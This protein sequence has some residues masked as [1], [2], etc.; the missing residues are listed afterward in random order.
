MRKTPLVE[1]NNDEQ[2]G[3]GD[4]FLTMQC[5]DVAMF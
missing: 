4:V 1:M 2:V 5:F 3:V